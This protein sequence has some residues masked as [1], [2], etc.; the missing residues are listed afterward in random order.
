MDS[1]NNPK[2]NP[3][4]EENSFAFVK[5][6]K[7][8]DSEVKFRIGPYLILETIGKGGMGEVFLAYDTSCGRQIALKRI[9]E[10]LLNF[11]QIHDRFLKEAHITSQLTHPSV[12]P[13]YT[14][15]KD[16]GTIYYTM[17]YVKGET[18]RQLLKEARNQEIKE[19]HLEPVQSSIPSLI[20]ILISICQ[21]IAYAHSHQ[22]L[23]RDIKPEN[24]IVG[25]F[26][27]VLILDWGLAKL[28]NDPDEEGEIEEKKGY[29]DLSGLTRV[30]KVVGTLN[31]MAPER[32]LGK[33]ANIQT[34]IYSL[35]VILYQML[36]LRFPFKRKSLKN[37]RE[38]MKYEELI[39]PTEIAPYRDVPRVL[40]K[41]AFTCLD[42]DPKKRYRRVEDLIRD[43]ENFIEGRAEW[44]HTKE[45]SP[46]KKSD[47]EFQENV[48]LAEH[49]AITRAAEVSD[50]MNLMI[51]KDSFG[52]N[53]RIEAK[54]R[55]KT[56]GHGV[57][58]LISVPEISERR[59]LNDGYCLWLGSDINKSTKLLRS[60]VEVV[61]APELVLKRYAWYK[62]TIEKIEHRINFYLNDEL[63]FSYVSHL[64]LVGTHVGLLSRD[65]D[66][67]IQDLNVFVAGQNVMVKCLAVP[68]AFL[69]HKNFTAALSEYRR[70]G[71]SFPGRQEGRE[72]M[73]RAGITLLEEA[74]NETNPL[75]AEKLYDLSLKEFEKLHETPGAP[76]EYLGKALVYQSLKEYEEEIKCFELALRRFP[77]HPL[78]FILH[79]QILS[80]M[81]ECS[82]SNR[83]ATY[84]FILLALRRLPRILTLP[85]SKRLFSSLERHWEE[86]FLLKAPSFLESS[87]Q[88]SLN[89]SSI[90][91]FWLNKGYVLTEIAEDMLKKTVVEP[92]PVNLFTLLFKMEDSE[93]LSK[94]I[95]IFSQK[96]EYRLLAAFVQELNLILEPQ[97]GV[98]ELFLKTPLDFKTKELFLYA[99]IDIWLAKGGANKAIIL[100]DS[101]DPYLENTL[102]LDSHKIWCYLKLNLFEEASKIFS[103]YPSDFLAK[104]DCPLF[105]LFGCFLAATD[106][107]EV[108]YIH[109]LGA[110]DIAYPRT[111]TLLAHFLKGQRIEN[112]SWQQRAF[113][114]EKKQLY[115]QISLYYHCIGEPK[116]SELWLQRASFDKT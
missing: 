88:W 103:N 30:G 97:E 11:K 65:A 57:G 68:D 102:E 105:S 44:F 27:E 20:R 55:L 100:L 5:G 80:R 107:E 69:A 93:F 59:H 53:V 98:D 76:L 104:E 113:F 77:S 4:P 108:A 89:F 110:I 95:Q 7:P 78:S 25:R 116:Q 70:I 94:A 115:R 48:F 26:G 2:E 46:A 74:K 58:F 99:L 64:P 87:L 49:I 60:T 109:F 111:W 17:P 18:L 52:E 24:I 66:Y 71:Y 96:E 14:I 62:I 8:L 36:T 54:V 63:Q 32:A 41:I 39:D 19:H 31:Y 56:H 15:H 43:L 73:F 23:H 13:I 106:G 28:M 83:K 40:S 61:H 47:W 75:L 67:E 1:E 3:T 6:Q 79:E 16:K 82:R 9:R 51:S 50:W 101:L 42:P 33:E 37:F 12:I 85:N 84:K 112:L 45:L 91:A 34:D 22:V 92:L 10:D 38:E 35:G 90:L 114:W 29:F 72:A 21:A 81:H 86:L